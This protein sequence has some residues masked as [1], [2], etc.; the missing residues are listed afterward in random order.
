ML[1]KISSHPQLEHISVL[2]LTGKIV[3]SKYN[4]FS[5]ASIIMAKLFYSFKLTPNMPLITVPSKTLVNIKP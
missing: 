1:G 3:P 5:S 2:Y 4:N